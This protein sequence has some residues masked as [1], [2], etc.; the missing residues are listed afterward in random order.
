LLQGK[1]EAA[2]REIAAVEG[3][4]E[5]IPKMQSFHHITY[6][7]ARVRARLGDSPQALHW[8]QLTADTGWPQYPMMERDRMLDP[9]RRDPAIARFLAALKLTL[10]NHQR[11]F[12]ADEP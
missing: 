4:A 9:V 3:E 11:E 8:L 1:A 6:G 12:G 5:K 2:R 10:E 7:I